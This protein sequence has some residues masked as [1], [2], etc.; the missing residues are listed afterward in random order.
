MCTFSSTSDSQSSTEQTS[1]SQASDKQ[2]EVD[3]DL[4]VPEKTNEIENTKTANKR[5]FEQQ[6]IC[7]W[8]PI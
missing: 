5:S 3:S 2:M 7:Y 8:Y 6:G 4:L 1:E